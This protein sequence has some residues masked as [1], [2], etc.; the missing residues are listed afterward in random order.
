[1]VIKNPP[2]ISPG[3]I[4]GGGGGLIIGMIFVLRIRGGGAYFRGGG[5]GLFSG[6]GGLL[7]GFYGI[8]FPLTFILKNI[9]FSI[10]MPENNMIFPDHFGS[11]S[12]GTFICI[13]TKIH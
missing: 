7:S 5:G 4:F 12:K 9:T 13:Y 8:P 3:L 10:T 1:M 6:G 11:I 2:K